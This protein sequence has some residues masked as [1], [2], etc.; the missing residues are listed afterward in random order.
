[1]G[2]VAHQMVLN[3]TF[4]GVIQLR[5]IRHKLRVSLSEKDVEFDKVKALNYVLV[6]V[7]S[8]SL[9]CL[10]QKPPNEKILIMDCPIS[11]CRHH[12]ASRLVAC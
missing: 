10:R 8:H 4:V 2:S 12:R 1:M 6:Y 11:L 5:G 9:R 3:A 7:F